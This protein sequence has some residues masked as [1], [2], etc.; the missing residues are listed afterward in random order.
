MKKFHIF[1][2]VFMMI[3]V[4]ACSDSTSTSSA[5]P[6]SNT[7]ASSEA[8]YVLKLSHGYPN[9]HYMHTFMEWFDEKIQERSDG[10][11]ALEIYPNAQLVSIDQQ[12]AAM[13]Q[14]QI[15]MSHIA[16][17]VLAGF[18]PRWNFFELPFL[19]DY[20]P[21]DPTVYLQNRNK[22][23]EDE[24]G[25][26]EFKRFMEEKGVKVLSLGYVDLFGS[27]FTTEKVVTD[28][29]SAEGLR[30]RTP[31]GIISPETMSSVGINGITMA[32]TEVITGLQQGVVDGL[33]TTPIYAH[34]VRLPIKTYSVLPLF[35]SV[36]SVAISLEKFESLPPD[37][38]NILLE[39]GAELEQHIHETIAQ[40]GEEVYA[41]L[42]EDMG[43]E[44]YYPTEEEIAEWKEAT[45]AAWELF[46]NEVEG[47]KELLEVHSE[48]MNE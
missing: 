32:G 46:A 20:D 28:I 40:A 23:L 26:G 13:L 43:V 8:E 7:S 39:T 5:E 31:G 1:L 41:K 27:I 6:S 2:L 33:L 14:G 45:Q 17:P 21:D 37:L 12:M 9:T 11:L 36:T 16:S 25:G 15:E 44:I 38:Q 22:F 34:D 10:R 3:C 24:R 42:E 29:K 30:I 18:D 35:G 48:V 4:T 47:G 19:F